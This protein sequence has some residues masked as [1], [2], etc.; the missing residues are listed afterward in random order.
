MG[1]PPAIAAWEWQASGL[2]EPSIKGRMK[3]EDTGYCVYFVD[4]GW[5]GSKSAGNCRASEQ[6]RSFKH[7]LSHP[8]PSL[9][10][11]LIPLLFLPPPHPPQ[12]H[13]TAVQAD[14]RISCYTCQDAYRPCAASNEETGRRGSDGIDDGDA[15]QQLGKIAAGEGARKVLVL[16]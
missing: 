1:D 8:P 13:A 4:F 16:V 12:I 7:S 2:A 10:P 14:Y 15:K 3:H 5:S 6:P 9:V 11:P